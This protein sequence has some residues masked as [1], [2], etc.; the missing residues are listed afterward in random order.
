MDSEQSAVLP[1]KQIHSFFFLLK[2][3]FWLSFYIFLILGFSAFILLVGYGYTYYHNRDLSVPGI[4]EKLNP[5]I[6][7]LWGNLPNNSVVYEETNTA[8][9]LIPPENAEQMPELPIVE[10]WWKDKI[11]SMEEAKNKSVVVLAITNSNCSYCYNIYPF[12]YQWQYQFNIEKPE[13]PVLKTA[14][15]NVSADP[16]DLEF[17]WQKITNVLNTFQLNIPVGISYDLGT[18]KDNE[19]LKSINIYNE[20][21]FPA[22][23]LI[24]THG[25]IRYQENGIGIKNLDLFPE[26]INQRRNR[27]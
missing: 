25:R 26:L 17:D 24:D 18:S 9:L 3:L 14:V 5:I 8:R 16:R 1:P 2:K 6:N 12:F 20:N 23:L 11:F 10:L 19:F 15:I 22:L 21:G 4:S 27:S 7:K 13:Q